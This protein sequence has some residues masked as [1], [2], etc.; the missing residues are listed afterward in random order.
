MVLVK[1][2]FPKNPAL[3]ILIQQQYKLCIKSRLW[4][5]LLVRLFLYKTADLMLLWKVPKTIHSF[6][7]RLICSVLHSV[8]PVSFHTS[9]AIVNHF[10]LTHSCFWL[11]RAHIST[12]FCFYLFTQSLRRKGENQNGWN[13]SVI[14]NKKNNNVKMRACFCLTMQVDALS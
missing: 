11:L 5:I 12:F 13:M 1:V 10:I 3:F 4:S 8:I 7:R 14:P 6:L 2:F 9:K